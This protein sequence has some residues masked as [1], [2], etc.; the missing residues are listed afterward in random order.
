MSDNKELQFSQS[1]S[2]S[3]F[4]VINNVFENDKG[5]KDFLSKQ[6]FSLEKG[7]DFENNQFQNFADFRVRESNY[8]PSLNKLRGTI[9]QP[10]TYID[11]KR[12]EKETLNTKEED[13]ELFFNS[14]KPGKYDSY[15]SKDEEDFDI[16]SV[17][18]NREKN[19]ALN[20]FKQ[21]QAELFIDRNDFSQKEKKIIYDNVKYGFIEL[22]NGNEKYINLYKEA[23][24]KDNIAL[25]QAKEIMPLPFIGDDEKRTQAREL[26][27]KAVNAQKVLQNYIVEEQE[28]LNNDSREYIKKHDA[29]QKDRVILEKNLD[30]IN[31]ELDKLGFRT[32][33]KDV[34]IVLYSQDQKDVDKVNSLYKQK[35][36]LVDTFYENHDAEYLTNER[37][38]LNIRHENFDKASEK[39]EN[40]D[41]AIKALG[42]NYSFARMTEMSLDVAEADIELFFGAVG[43]KLN[44]V[45]QEAYDDMI[46]INASIKEHKQVI[47]PLPVNFSDMSIK[48]FDDV[49]S[50]VLSENSF[51]ILTALSYGGVLRLAGSRGVSA[52]VAKRTVQGTFFSVEAGGHLSELELRQKNARE[53]IPLLRKQLETVTDPQLKKEILISL[54]AHEKAL[55]ITGLQKTINPLLYGGFATF[56]ETFG[57]L[58]II[59]RLNSMPIGKNQFKNIIR[60]GKRYGFNVGVEYL[61]EAGTQA[62]HNAADYWVLK[63]N[64]SFFEGID[65]NFN[66]NVLFSTIAIQGPSIGQTALATI[67]DEFNTFADIRRNRKYADQFIELVQGVKNAKTYEGKLIAENKLNE[68][69]EEV[70]V[71]DSEQFTNVADMSNE[72]IFQ[73][74]ENNRRVRDE[75]Q[76][77]RDLAV[78]KGIGLD[79]RTKEKIDE[80]TKNIIRLKSKNEELLNKPSKEREAKYKEIVKKETVDTESLFYFAQAAHFINLLKGTNDIKVFETTGDTYEAELDSMKV[81]LNELLSNGDISIK[82]YNDYIKGFEEGSNA[83]FVQSTN[84]VLIFGAN[85]AVGIQNSK[86]ILEKAMTA[87]AAIHEA[88]HMYD[89]KKGVVK[90]GEVVK[91][92]KA[93]IQELVKTIEQLDKNS[94]EYKVAKARLDTYTENGVLDLREIKT[95]FGEFINAGIINRDDAVLMYYFK[96][97]FNS[98][99][100]AMPFGEKLAPVRLKTADDVLNYIKNFQKQITKGAVKLQLP[101]EE[102]ITFA[103][104]TFSKAALNPINDLVPKDIKTKEDYDAFTSNEKA[105]LPVGKALRPNGI[106]HNIIKKNTTSETFQR[107]LDEVTMRILNFNPAA[108]RKDGTTVGI[109]AFAERIFSDINFGKMEAA[110]ELATKPKT[111]TIDQPTET[112]RRSIDIADETQ[113]QE[114]LTPQ[115]LDSQIKKTLKLTDEVVEKVKQAVRKTYGTRLPDIRSKEYRTRLKDALVVELRKEIQSIFGREQEYNKFLIKYIP[116]LHRTLSADRWVQIERR[117]PKGKKI[118]VDSKRITSVKEVRKLQEQG[119]IRKDVKPASGPNLNTKLKTPNNEQIMAFFRGTNM[120]DVLG[121]TITKS[122]FGTRKDALAAAVVEKVGFD[123]AVNV[124]NTEINVLE[125]MRGVQE[126]TGIEQL[127]NDVQVIADVLDVNPNVSFSA[128][129]TGIQTIEQFNDLL[130]LAQNSIGEFLALENKLKYNG[131][132]ILSAIY[133]PIKELHNKGGL[134]K[135]TM[136]NTALQKVFGSI[137]KLKGEKNLGDVGERVVYNLFKEAGFLAPGHQLSEKKVNIKPFFTFKG[138][139]FQNADIVFVLENGQE[140]ALEIKFAAAGIVNAGKIT[141]SSYDSKGNF[142]FSDPTLP[143][144]IKDIVTEGAKNVLE[145]VKEFE[146]LLIEEFGY[147]KGISLNEIQL[148]EI[149]PYKNKDGKNLMIFKQV[150]GSNLWHPKIEAIKKKSNFTVKDDGSV[151]TYIYNKKGNFYALFIGEGKGKGLHHMGDPLNLEKRLGVTSVKGDHGV[152]FRLLAESDKKLKKQGKK[153]YGFRLNVEAFFNT[154]NIEKTS[155]FNIRN[156]KNVQELKIAAN[157][158]VYAKKNISFSKAVINS[159][160]IKDAKGITILDFDDTLATTKS[161]VRFTDPNGNTGTL[162]AEQYASQYQDL[163]DQGYTFDFTDFNKVVG[164]KVA[165]LFKKA[166]KL[167]SKF[168]PSNMF[169]LTARPPVSAEAIFDFLKANGLNIPIENITGLGNSTS[170]AKALWVADKVAQGYNDFYFADDALQNVQAVKNMLDQ[171]DVKSKVQQAKV[172]FSKSIN[173]DFNKQLEDVTGIEAK[174]RFSEIKARKRGASK[175]KFRFFIPPSHEDFV[176]LLYNFIGKGELGNKH[177]DFLEKALIKPLNRAFREYDTAKQSITSDY[178]S[179]NKQMPDVKKMFTKKT[180]DGDFTY[181]DAIRVYLWN[182]HGHAIPGISETDQNNLANIVKKDARLLSYAEALNVISKRSDYIAP[183]VGWEAFNIKMDLID[184]TDRVGRAEFFAEFFENADIIFSQENLNKIEAAYGKGFRSALEDM[185]YRIKTGRNRPKGQNAIVNALTN[186]VNA[187]VGTVMFFN[188]RSLTLQQMSIVNFINYAD[189]NIFQAAKAFANQKQYWNDWSMIFNSDMLKQR[190]GGI[191]TDVNGAELAREISQSK[192]PIRSLIRKLLQLGFKPT[193][194]GDNI[195]IATGGALFYRNRLNTYLKQNLSKSEA[196]RRAFIDFQEIAEATQQSARPDMVSQQQASD[197]GKWILAFQNVTSQFNRLGKKAF[198]DIYNRRITPPNKTLLQS[199]ISNASRILY[200]FAVQN[201]IFYGLQSAL[202]FM[203]FDEDPEDERLLSKQERM[204]SGSIDS[205]LRGSGVMGAAVATLKNMAVKFIEQREATGYSKDESAVIL[206]LANLSPPLG[207]KLRKIVNAEKTLNYNENIISEMETFDSDNPHWSAATNYIEAITNV[208]ANRLYN[209]T[210]NLRQA[211]DSQNQSW[212]RALMFLGWSQYNLGIQNEEIEKY[213]NK[214]KSRKALRRP[215]PRKQSKRRQL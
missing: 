24:E 40:A 158:S 94:T 29:Y 208:P 179:L 126:I 95:V 36:D 202:F 206:E 57:T 78:N 214:V 90:N 191:R 200:Y 55:N 180:P 195:A 129:I 68:F 17:V 168:G 25:E 73:V 198:L 39:I 212:Q 30:N 89:I 155:G 46:S 116:A 207:I 128:A 133:D 164:G 175:G 111:T 53:Q 124:I 59:R 120:Q 1:V 123:A 31:A 35:A 132:P 26:Q 70:N 66:M 176:G 74:L 20:E 44:L 146:N 85:I 100:L 45:S 21:R 42:K 18:S 210:L 154:N 121:Y 136:L 3:L 157:K 181:E 104:A 48:N 65:A 204:L 211:L 160:T 186:F 174:K 194:I 140:V 153:V 108:K 152:K 150:N 7:V 187:A 145:V 177:R 182:K 170:E 144:E 43:K 72:D 105:F 134:L 118:F 205:V 61:E 127:E 83:S 88:Q 192:Y 162:N 139:R 147:P 47:H 169:V 19:I 84:E 98:A 148:P 75:R 119:L 114:E 125:R 91:D 159:R 80:I 167:Q 122:T 178:K 9:F 197:A 12:T 64:K 14:Q 69:L 34:P 188:I 190:R 215:K 130:T 38:N 138:G 2:K 173:K 51:S 142:T 4:N 10:F 201:L 37:Y 77:I 185:L 184:A 103:G 11:P 135:D 109:E 101:P 183:V 27:S 189:N 63:E 87:Y 115:Q 49:V 13:L 41:I 67:R 60:S 166:L 172:N 112:G 203:M 209:K 193:Q 99:L 33:D 32:E 81:K 86:N 143:Q 163:L 156:K 196:E 97:L 71:K 141:I 6:Y 5:F 58:S 161:L 50:S 149:S 117:V 137:V 15:L 110:K 23:L 16:L 213:R 106:I 62:L 8:E 56:A 96:N 131:V 93:A 199:D 22:F 113:E 52:T 151:S 102:E 165:P 54:D 171:F 79:S 92:H 107:T 28:N 82:D 76:K